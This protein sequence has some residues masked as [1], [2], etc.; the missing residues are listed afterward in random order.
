MIRQYT[1]S[2]GESFETITLPRGT[3][4]FRGISMEREGTG[5]IDSDRPFTELIGATSSIY[6]AFCVDPHQLTYFHPAPLVSDTVQQYPM[7]VIYLTNYD[8]EL[9]LMVNPSTRVRDVPTAVTVPCT[10]IQETT[11]C[12]GPV[13]N[14]DPCLTPHMFKEFP[15]IHGFIALT[16]ND[17]ARYTTGYFPHAIR[18]LPH[19][20]RMTVP[21]VAENATKRM[22][23]PEIAI[24]PYHVRT[25]DGPQIVSARIADDGIFNY[26]L[27]QRAH[28][29][30]FPF[31]YVTEKKTYSFMDL[32][33]YKN[34]TEMGETPRNDN[35]LESPLFKQLY[36]IVDRALSPQGILVDG[37]RYWFT[38]DLRTGFYVAKN[39]SST[40][41]R[42]PY[43]EG[44][45]GSFRKSIHEEYNPANFSV[46]PITYPA[47]LKQ[48]MQAFLD[49]HGRHRETIPSAAI[50]EDDITQHVGKHG[51]SYSRQY[52]LQKNH[53]Q[54][55]A[56]NFRLEY[57]FPRTD[58]RPL[59]LAKYNSPARTTRK[60]KSSVRTTAKRH[61]SSGALSPL[62]R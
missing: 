10:E 32:R 46:V 35:T 7:Y 17:S 29:S 9:V 37:V 60:H 53:P 14:S 49:R 54:K 3:V 51:L 34:C 5:R 61:G 21:F 56:V 8:L 52:S 13:R 19:Y 2:T 50:T 25:H 39:D 23:M 38:I 42:E 24:H 40:L 55:Y 6:N 45:V 12:G 43:I 20:A 58:L 33:L 11:R 31:F 47:S 36:A 62:S 41:H 1:L 30:F 26:I 16:K 57:M 18:E 15:H 44:L 59:R 27:R 4:L 48:E 22:G 28:F